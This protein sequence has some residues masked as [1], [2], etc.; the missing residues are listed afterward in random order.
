[1]NEPATERE[2]A[3]GVNVSPQHEH[4]ASAVASAPISAPPAPTA[5][6]TDWPADWRSKFAAGDR[7]FEERLSR[8][9]SPLDIVKS[10]REM[11]SKLSGGE[12]RRDLPRDASAEQLAAWRAERGIPDEPSGYPI[13]LP[14]GV[15]LGEADQP[16]VEDFTAFVHPK[17]WTPQQVNDALA[18]YHDVKDKAAAERAEADV[19]F[20][21]E[22]MAA[23]RAEW[24]ADFKRTVNSIEALVAGWP[25]GL[26]DR[27]LAGRSADGKQLGD[28]PAFLRVLAGFQRELNP[29]PSLPPAGGGSPLDRLAEIRSFRREHPDRYDADKAMQAEELVLIEAEQRMQGRR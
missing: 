23:L 8:F 3:S 27:V 16:L 20:H 7:R 21:S 10:Y 19:A 9:A 14:N 18:W 11:E 24:G 25:A 29:L 2:D 12:Y 22:S 5:S 28:D 17:N 6:A 26:A 4:G 13:E 15:V 1:M